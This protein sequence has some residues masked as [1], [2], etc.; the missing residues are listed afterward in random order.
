M[1]LPG[2]L[3]EALNPTIQVT[4][5]ISKK[6]KKKTLHLN[7]VLQIWQYICVIC[8]EPSEMQKERFRI[9]R[10]KNLYTKPV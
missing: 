10:G 4:V 2:H 1:K 8:L 6:K 5:R 3:P 7:K 9:Y